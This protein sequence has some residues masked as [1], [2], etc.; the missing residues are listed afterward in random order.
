[1][2]VAFGLANALR[3]AGRLAEAE[4][5]ARRVIEFDPGNSQ[6][7]HSL[8]DLYQYYMNRIADGLLWRRKGFD[9]DPEGVIYP[10]L[11]ALPNVNFGGWECR[12]GTSFT[13]LTTFLPAW[14]EDFRSSSHSYRSQRRGSTTPTPPTST[15]ACLRERGG[16]S[17]ATFATT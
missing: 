9:L 5:E 2:R 1:M 17:M 14:K 10:E 16:V 3:N 11:A 7:K 13:T 4:A 12:R 8:G 6:A 15:G